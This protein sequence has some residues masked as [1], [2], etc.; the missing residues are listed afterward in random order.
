MN[1][2]ISSLTAAVN[3]AHYPNVE[4]VTSQISGHDLAAKQQLVDYVTSCIQPAYIEYLNA[5]IMCVPLNAF[6]AARLF[7]L[8]SGLCT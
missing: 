1:K 5:P 4:A 6:K 2:L 3:L 7:S 8:S